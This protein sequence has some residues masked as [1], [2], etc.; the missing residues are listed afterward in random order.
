[1]QKATINH[2]ESTARILAATLTLIA[3]EQKTHSPPFSLWTPELGAK[4]IKK[5]A[6]EVV[7][8]QA[9]V[10]WVDEG[11]PSYGLMLLGKQALETSLLGSGAGRLKGPFLVDSDSISRQ[12]KTQ[13]LVSKAK[14]LAKLLNY[15]F[16]SAKI[17][18]DPAVIRGFNS[19]GFLAAEIITSLEGQISPVI[20]EEIT[21][22]KFPSI[23][24]QSSDN[25]DSSVLLDKLGDLF[26]DGHYLHS[27]V[28]P[29]D[30][31]KRLWAKV[32]I[33]KIEA[34]NTALFALDQRQK[35]PVG[36]ALPCLDGEEARLTILH[37]SES[38]R[39]LGLGEY[40]LKNC[41]A[42]VYERGARFLKAETASWNLPAL[43]LYIKVGL[44]PVAPFVAL[45]YAI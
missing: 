7:S 8:G 17:T 33:A 11:H 28:L 39:N 29:S 44:K 6:Q 14:E 20:L 2:N 30:F 9:Q 37:V 38:F 24:L 16:L 41:L 13:S 36:L 34:G 18:H 21:H 31:S 3:R 32:A 23:E 42:Q 19:E 15:R 12:E 40:L 35:E 43:S 25:V 27:P 10:I 5:A 1:M 4:E 26:Y 22:L 45:H